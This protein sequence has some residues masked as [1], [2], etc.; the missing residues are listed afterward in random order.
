MIEEAHQ[1]IVDRF[2][3]RGDRVPINSQKDIDNRERHSFVAI[4]E[5]VVLNE[6]FQKCR[7]L[8]NDRVVIA[9]LG[10]VKS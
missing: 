1:G 9:G 4:H 8:V 7:S 2:R 3:V 6:A 10:A 5:R